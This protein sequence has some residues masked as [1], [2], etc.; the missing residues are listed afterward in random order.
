MKLPKEKKEVRCKWV[1]KRKEGIPTVEEARYKERL[2]DK[3]YNHI[4]DVDFIDV[5]S[6][7]VKH[8]SIQTLLSIVVMHDFELELLDVK[9]A[10]LH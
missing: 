3:S 4:P 2:V 1:F 8:N 7:V 6:P 10:F 5:F 9:T